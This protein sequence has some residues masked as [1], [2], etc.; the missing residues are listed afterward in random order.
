M[1]SPPLGRAVRSLARAPISLYR[2]GYGFLLGHRVLMLE[3]IGRKTGLPRYVVLE[4]VRQLSEDS[5]VVAAGMGTKADWYRNIERQPQVRV[6]VGRRNAA[7]A[8][9]QPIE[10][11]EARRH[12]E[13]YRA[14]RPWTWRLLR[15]LISKLIGQPGQTDEDLFAT[16]PLVELRLDVP[17]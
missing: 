5:F 12:F 10:Q 16:V 2:A 11:S 6:W 17:G 14:E 3:H 8:V 1:A 13:A 9:A 15:P 7:V 4:V